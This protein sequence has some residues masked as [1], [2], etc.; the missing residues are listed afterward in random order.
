MW[1]KVVIKI[2]TKAYFSIDPVPYWTLM[3]DTY[4]PC[5]LSTRYVVFQIRYSRACRFVEKLKFLIVITSKLT[6]KHELTNEVTSGR[7]RVEGLVIEG[8][9][10]LYVAQCSLFCCA[11]GSVPDQWIHVV[12]FSDWTHL[13][14]GCFFTKLN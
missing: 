7:F 10:I 14:K 3:M 8:L 5:G 9:V 11:L 4:D 2:H 1:K 6:S 13:S 12:F